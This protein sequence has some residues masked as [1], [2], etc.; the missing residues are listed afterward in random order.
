MTD[1]PAEEE[2]LVKALKWLMK[3]S[4]TASR[5]SIGTFYDGGCGC[6]QDY[7]QVPEDIR[8]LLEKIQA[9]VLEGE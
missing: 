1:S 8:P 5:V 4:A 9:E 7:I 6:C 3:E 2:L